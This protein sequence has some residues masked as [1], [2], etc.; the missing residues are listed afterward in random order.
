M[1]GRLFTSII[2]VLAVAALVVGINLFADARLADVRVDLTQNRLY[3]LSPGT[4]KILADLKQ[5]I[6][7]SLFYSR[8]LGATAATFGDYADRVREMLQEYAAAAHGKIRLKFYNPEPFSQTED[9]AL[10]DGLQGVPVDQDGT[11]VYFGLSG[12]NLLDDHR[13]IP[14]FQPDRARLLEYDLTKLVYELSNPKRPV[15]G[16]MSSLPL[17]G[18]ARLMMMTQGREGAQPYASTLLIQQTNQMKT[19][20][21]D[22][23]VIPKDV[24]VLLVAEAQHLS[25]NTLYAIDQFV[26]RGGRLMVMVDPWSE[27]LAAEPTQTGMPPSDTHSDLRKLFHAWGIEFN[28]NQ[29]VGNLDSAWRVRAGADPTSGATNYVAWFNIG[30]DGINHTDPA[31]ADLQQVSVASAGFIS[32]APHAGI[33]FTPLLTATGRDGVIPVSAVKTPEPAKILASFKPDG[34]PRVIAA[35]IHGELKSAFSGPPALA[36]GQQRPA[37]FPAYIA[38]TKAAADLVVVA[39]SDI[40]ADRFWVRINDFFGQKT[41]VPF[42]DDGPFVANLIDTLAGGEALISLRSRGDNDHPFTLVNAMQARAEAKFRQTQQALQQ[43]LTKVEQQL[44]TLRDGKT[45]GPDAASMQA[46]ITPQQQQAI[47]AARKDIVDTRE[48]LRAVQRD[49]NHDIG[50]LEAEL[51]IFNIVL[52]PAVLTLLALG[53]GLVRRQR[54]ARARA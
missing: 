42:S 49:L 21:T 7:L 9:Q 13:T 53:L 15:V 40:L 31:T 3:T 30:K 19:I 18:N 26:M 50:R 46:L 35:R 28:P 38:H 5:P 29:V 10:A 1:R 23:Q 45:G 8:R 27:A 14:F 17:D 48:Q 44:S 51:R 34:K 2:G 37:D 25:Q 54:R 39:D 32:K 22:A 41:A 4:R 6:T 16:V 52:V 33:Q 43:H 11:K 36:K 24:Q 47:D 12:S 20:P